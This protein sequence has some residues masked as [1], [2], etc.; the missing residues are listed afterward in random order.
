MHFYIQ[1]M[2]YHGGMKRRPSEED[3]RY[4]SY[5]TMA[6]GNRGIMAFCYQAPGGPPYSGEFKKDDYAMLDEAHERTEIWYGFQKVAAELKAFEHVYLSFQWQSAKAVWGTAP[7]L[8][9]ALTEPE[10]ERI[11]AF[12]RLRYNAF[13]GSIRKAECERGLVIG[14]FKDERGRDGY[15]A[16]NY[17]DPY[18]KNANK[19]A[20]YFEKE[21][22]KLIVFVKG[23]PEEI[24]I[25]DGS[26]A[27]ELAPG[28]GRFIIAVR[29]SKT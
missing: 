19:I 17:A 4:Q 3:I 24:A 20:L 25:G 15:M 2:S 22:G 23:V 9:P 11:P 10:N 1:T 7:G 28:E 13:S 21:I 6:Y 16:V 18:Y 14:C 8:F 5:I 29:E 12:E 27:A 26:Y